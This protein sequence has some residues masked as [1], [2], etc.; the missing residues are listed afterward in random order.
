[1]RKSYLKWGLISGAILIF[2]NLIFYA[3]SGF[4]MDMSSTGEV[5]GYSAMIISLLL[6]F[7]GIRNYRD[8]KQ[9]GKISFGK[10]LALGTMI[11]VVAAVIPGI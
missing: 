4:E 8:K 1:M 2:L 7:A 6:I 10:G 9:N 11:S 5:F 3:L